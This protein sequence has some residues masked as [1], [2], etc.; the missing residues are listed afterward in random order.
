M[1]EKIFLKRVEEQA[2]RFDNNFS[3]LEEVIQLISGEDF[4]IDERKVL[5]VVFI[6]LTGSLRG[7]IRAIGVIEQ[8]LKY[9]KFGDALAA[10]KK[11]IEKE[12]FD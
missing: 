2:K 12:L 5:S 6:N 4:T 3:F 10:Y 7:A 8:I 11:K 1:E 9:K